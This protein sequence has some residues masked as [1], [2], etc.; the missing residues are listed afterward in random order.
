MPGEKS[1]KRNKSDTSAKKVVARKSTA[2][3]KRANAKPRAV[4]AK[5][6]KRQ[7]RAAAIRP[8]TQAYGNRAFTRTSSPHAGIS[9][10]VQIPPLRRPRLKAKSEAK[11]LPELSRNRLLLRAAALPA[12]LIVGS[13]VF[14][15]VQ[16][17]PQKKTPTAP[18]ATVRTQPDYKPLL[19]SA[20]KAST[21][22]YDAKRNLVTYNTTFSGARITVSQQPLP[23]NFANDPAAL[24]K[25]AD[26]IKATQQIDTD[27][28]PL[29]VATN[30]DTNDQ[31]ALYAAPKVLVFIHCAGKLDDASWK[32]FIELLEAKSWEELI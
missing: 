19:P 7:P 14:Y 6:T 1:D 23:A 5:A 3:Q 29:L 28:G 21:T 18:V 20:E 24:Q 17:G 10:T 15:G 26:T 2:T 11:N 13:L 4:T 31:F 27:K 32:A 16:A 12:L 25:A 22:K 9:I 30:P 8:D